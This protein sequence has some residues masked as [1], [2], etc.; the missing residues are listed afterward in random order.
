MSYCYVSSGFSNSKGLVKILTTSVFLNT[1]FLYAMISYITTFM[2]I[3]VILEVV[4]SSSV[5]GFIKTDK[6]SKLVTLSTPLS[7]LSRLESSAI[8]MFYNV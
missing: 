4:T 3:S 7:H 1:L 6:V 8:K 5:S 2:I